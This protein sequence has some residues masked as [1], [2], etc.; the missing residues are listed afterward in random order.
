MRSNLRDGASTAYPLE[1]QQRPLGRTHDA[2]S[3]GS[4]A[5]RHLAEL[6]CTNGSQW[7][8][9]DSTGIDKIEEAM[10]KDIPTSK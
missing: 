8:T 3:L 6:R 7:G 1:R 2:S 4:G 10:A 9:S 5:L